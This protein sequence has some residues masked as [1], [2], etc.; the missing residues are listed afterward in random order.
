MRPYSES[1]D[2]NRDP[3]LNVIQPLFADRVR[4]LEIGSGTGQHAV[5]FAEKMPQLSWQ[6]SD[7]EENHAGIRLWLIE[8]ALKNVL[9]PVSLA[10]CDKSSWSKLTSYDAVFSANAVHIMGKKDVE[11]LFQEVGRVLEARGLLVLYGPFNYDGNYTSE[12]NA[13]FD[14]WLKNNNSQSS[15]R[16]FEWLD[17]LAKKEGLTLLSDYE[18]PANNRI[19]VWRN[20]NQ[21]VSG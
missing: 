10:A 6:T 20:S 7:L 17:G 2:Q 18:M 8:A 1:C 9:A 4:V 13:R 15:I 3:I 11:C 16:D 19:L 12:S 21:V 14:I 5:Y